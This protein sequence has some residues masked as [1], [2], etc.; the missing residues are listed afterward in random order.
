MLLH[1]RGVK[2]QA[3]LRKCTVSPEI[4]CSHKQSMYVD[5][6]AFF[7][8]DGIRANPITYE[9]NL[10]TYERYIRG[11]NLL[12]GAILHPG[13]NLHQGANCAYKRGLKC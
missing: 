13:V 7:S 3:S 10:L 6:G 9:H 4:C 1:M 8:H 11:A 2:T 5:K 12:P